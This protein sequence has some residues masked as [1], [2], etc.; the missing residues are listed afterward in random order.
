MYGSGLTC[1][2]CAVRCARA[3]R[4]CLR[5]PTSCIAARIA[6]AGL[7][8][9]WQIALALTYINHPLRRLL[10]RR[11]IER[12]AQ[13]NGAASNEATDTGI[14]VLCLSLFGQRGGGRFV[15]GIRL[16][17]AKLAPLRAG[18]RAPCHR[19]S[20]APASSTP[21][22]RACTS[23]VDHSPCCCADTPRWPVVNAE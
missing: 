20:V 13:E 8:S 23:P 10:K 16:D 18:M 7:G 9:A 6:G 14:Q 19:K 22:P 5:L 1:W 2:A 15:G 11:S 17:Q 3:R 4:R 21:P 12:E